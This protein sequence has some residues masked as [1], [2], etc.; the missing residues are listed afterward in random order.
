MKIKYRYVFNRAGKLNKMGLGLIQIEAYKQGKKA[1]FSSNIFVRENEFSGIVVNHPHAADLNAVLTDMIMR[2]EAI[3]LDLWRHGVEPTL[4]HLRQGWKDKHSLTDF[5]WFATKTVEK[6]GRKDSTKKNLLFT[7]HKI[8]EFRKVNVSEVDYLYLKGFEGWLRDKNM[9]SSTIQKEM[10][11]VRT[12]IGE[13]IKAGLIVK[14]PFDR[15]LLP[16]AER[17]QHVVLSEEELSIVARV[18]LHESV[19]DAFVFCCQTGMRYSDYVQL[20][21]RNFPHINNKVWLVYRTV[22][23]NVEIRIPYYLIGELAHPAIGCNAAVNRQLKRICQYAGINKTITFHSA[24]H[25]FATRMI[26]LG[27]P[28][29]TVQHMLGHSSVKMT[30]H[31]AETTASKIEADMRKVFSVV[32]AHHG[33]K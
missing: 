6:S 8:E 2:L 28:I 20:S 33:R 12:L 30:E 22:K 5:V 25:T 29:T 31:Y 1:Y 7:I 32:P 26:T 13:A 24:R 27:V 23:T 4:D 3:E 9:K 11:N 17:K 10:S 21:E 18:P 15:Y 14:N 19:R 16:R